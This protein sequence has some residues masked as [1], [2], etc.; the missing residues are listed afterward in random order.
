MLVLA[1]GAQKGGSS[2]QSMIVARAGFRSIPDS[3]Q[4]PIF[5]NSSIAFAKLAEFL[6]KEAPRANYWSKQ[7]WHGT[8]SL[9]ALAAHPHV[10]LLNIVR[11]IRDVLVSR[12]FHEIRR[13]RFSGDMADYYREM[14]RAAMKR[15]VGFHIFWHADPPEP[16]LISF[17]GLRRNFAASV[18][19][20][21]DF[22]GVPHTPDL[23]EALRTATDAAEGTGRFA[24]GDGLF[25]R[26]SAIGDW[27]NHLDA[28]IVDDLDAMCREQGYYRL[29]LA[30][31]ARFPH[32]EVDYAAGR[33]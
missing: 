27:A 4:N 8:P 30:A 29:L 10:R 26:K 20:M 18:A 9:K 19:P 1:N 15:Y 22:L 32:L 7:H 2:W 5:N 12:Y 3:Y 13:K 14:G 25:M 28:E 21:L 11:D 23:I 31:R 33:S 16:H 17:E 24:V 6:E